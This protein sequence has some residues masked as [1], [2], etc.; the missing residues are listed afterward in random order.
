MDNFFG[1]AILNGTPMDKHTKHLVE[2][3][4]RI[5]NELSDTAHELEEHLAWD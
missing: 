4:Q 5:S 1:N 2:R 3:L